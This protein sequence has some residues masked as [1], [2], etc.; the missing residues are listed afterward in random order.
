VIREG[1]IKLAYGDV[2]KDGYFIA[3]YFE[4]IGSNRAFAAGFGGSKEDS[5]EDLTDLGSPV[6]LA[7][8]VCGVFRSISCGGSC[9]PA[10]LWWRQNGVTYQI[11]IKFSSTLDKKE[12]ERILVQAANASVTVRSK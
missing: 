12:Q 11:Q 6:A 10:N 3:L 5:P 2:S 4:E 7:G 1:D 9:A 8:G